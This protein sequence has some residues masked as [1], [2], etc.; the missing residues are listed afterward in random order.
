MIARFCAAL[1]F[2]GTFATSAF[3]DNSMVDPL[4]AIAGAEIAAEA[5]SG[6]EPA[7]GL[8]VPASAELGTAELSDEPE[9]VIGEYSRAFLRTLPEMDG[10]EQWQCLAEALYFEARG[11][12][13]LGQF[14]VA[15]VIIN[16]AESDDFPETV[17]KVVNQ[18]TG[19][20][21]RCQFTYTCDGLPETVADAAAWEMVGK[22]ARLALDGHAEELTNGALFYHTKAVNPN[23][24]EVFFRTTTIGAHHFYNPEAVLAQG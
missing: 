19:K 18:G 6:I 4:A 21:W 2:A 24:A 16:R 13:A 1:A 9:P 11:E 20:K 10:G 22:V 3:A 5:R 17:C 15:E 14:A 8:L 23:W 7:G 12:P